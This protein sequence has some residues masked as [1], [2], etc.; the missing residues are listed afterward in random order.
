MNFDV[1]IVDRGEGLIYKVDDF[2]INFGIGFNRIS[3]AISITTFRYSDQY[4][5]LFKLP[6]EK[7]E[8]VLKDI[9]EYFRKRKQKI[10][11]ISIEPN[12]P[13]KTMDEL[14]DE[15][16]KRRDNSKT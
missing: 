16:L 10:E 5:N 1:E 14:L 13:L 4:F 6:P 7:E 12:Y 2:V 3:Q 11:F 9:K 15:R 8:K